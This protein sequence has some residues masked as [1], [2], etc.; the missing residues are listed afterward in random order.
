MTNPPLSR[1]YKIILNPT[2]GHGNG[3]RSL[4]KI[5]EL[6]ARYGVSYD[7]T[8]T[9]HPGHGIELTHQA[10]KDGCRAV[11]AAGGDG[12][13]NEIINGLMR[14]KLEGLSVPAFGVLGVGRGNDF[15]GSMGI[16]AS[17]EEEGQALVDHQTRVIDIGRVVGGKYPEGRYFGNFVGIGFDAITTI[18]VS[19]L[20]R[21]GGYFSFLVGVLQTVFVYNHAPLA[22]IEYD[23]KEITQ[24]S[25]LITV[26]NGRRLGGNFLMAPDSVPDDGLFDLCV[27]EQMSSFEVIR[28]IPHFTKGDQA[29][30]PQIKTGRAAK[31]IIT[32]LDGSLPADTDGEIICVDGTRLEV[33]ILPRQLEI[34]CKK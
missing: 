10:V 31:V 34:I 7:L 32:A 6:L 4:P 23:G 30:Q 28:M 16:P 8:Q 1:P 24:R 17:L 3:L 12:T 9:T 20:P 22:K 11:I 33:E 19:R 14:C 18:Q 13:V 27:A 25:L 2:A 15:A 21:W 5:K 29:T 26:M